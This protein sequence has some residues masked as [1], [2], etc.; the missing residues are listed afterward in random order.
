MKTT[1]RDVLPKASHGDTKPKNR[2]GGDLSVVHV[3][4]RRS[5]S[6]SRPKDDDA[7]LNIFFFHDLAFLLIFCRFPNRY[8]SRNV[9]RR[10]IKH[11]NE[12]I[13]VIKAYLEHKKILKRSTE[14]MEVF[15]A[16]IFPK[17]VEPSLIDVSTNK[18]V[19]IEVM[20]QKNVLFFISSL[21]ITLEEISVLK[22]VYDEISKKDQYKIVWIPIV[23]Q[24]TD[25][26][27]K[28]FED[29]KHNFFYG[30]KDEGGWIQQFT[31]KA[32]SLAI[33]PALKEAKISIELVHI[34][35]NQKGQYD[36]GILG[37][38]WDTME[39]FFFSKT[40]KK[41][42]KDDISKE[43]QKLLSY[44]SESGW[45]MLSKG[46]K[47]IFTG[48]GTTILQVVNE[49]EKWKGCVREIGFDVAIK[50]YFDNI[51]R[52]NCSRV[53]IPLGVGKIPEHMH[54]A[55]CSR[56]MKTYMSF[57]CCHVDGAPNALH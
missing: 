7:E 23:E 44:K 51:N 33:D 2:D 29:D 50:Q 35:K 5:T 21:D 24:W 48:H 37:R 19:N 16:L 34:G 31:T 6:S 40:E 46:S 52:I 3:K 14:V 56:V 55:D 20:K 15:K 18:S 26:L 22:P 47:V 36:D 53:D 45:V 9:L 1:T 13:D 41:T 57:K 12:Q 42:E 38:F 10:T 43:T 39:S 30:G 11:A 27:K 49:A 32:K 54:C 28:K 25:D 8:L 4:T 17:D